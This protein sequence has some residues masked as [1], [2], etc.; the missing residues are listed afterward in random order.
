MDLKRGG[1]LS[2]WPFIR[3]STIRHFAINTTGQEALLLA[4]F[5]LPA[6]IFLCFSGGEMAGTGTRRE[7]NRH[8]STEVFLPAPVARIPQIHQ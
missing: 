5:R 6:T 8:Y 2:E 4:M 3:A 7:T 1:L